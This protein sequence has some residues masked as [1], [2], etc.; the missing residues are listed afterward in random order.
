MS[1]TKKQNTELSFAIALTKLGDFYK[2][3]IY[4]KR[5]VQALE[6]DLKINK[7]INIEDN[8]CTSKDPKDIA[9][10]KLKMQSLCLAYHHLASIKKNKEDHSKAFEFF[11]L[12][13]SISKKYVKDKKL[14]KIINEDT[15]KSKP[16]ISLF[17]KKKFFG[18]NIRMS[19]VK[20]QMATEKDLLSEIFGK[21]EEKRKKYM[22]PNLS[23]SSLPM[24]FNESL[25]SISTNLHENSFKPLDKKI[26]NRAETVFIASNRGFP[27]SNTKAKVPSDIRNLRKIENKAALIIQKFFKKI[28]KKK[29]LVSIPF[30]EKL[31]K[32]KT[33]TYEDIVESSLLG[34]S[35]DFLKENSPRH[36]PNSSFLTIES[37]IPEKSNDSN[38]P[39]EKTEPEILL[40]SRPDQ[41]LS[42]TSSPSLFQ[43]LALSKVDLYISHSILNKLYT[44]KI[45]V[46]NF[47]VF[48][49]SIQY[50][51]IISGTYDK[52]T[53]TLYYSRIVTFDIIKNE[54]FFYPFGFQTVWPIIRSEIIPEQDLNLDYDDEG[55]IEYI[56]DL[57]HYIIN[58]SSIDYTMSGPRL[59]FRPKTPTPPE[60]LPEFE[61]NPHLYSKDGVLSSLLIFSKHEKPVLRNIQ[62]L[63]DKEELESIGRT[64]E[65]GI[66][67]ICDTYLMLR[68]QIISYDPVH[69]T[70]LNLILTS[71][72]SNWTETFVLSW[73]RVVELFRSTGFD[74]DIGDVFCTGRLP[75][76]ARDLFYSHFS[77][78]FSIEG[79]KI[80]IKK[81][82]VENAIDIDNIFMT[83]SSSIQECHAEWDQVLENSEYLNSVRDTDS[84]CLGVIPCVSLKGEKDLVHLK[85]TV[86]NKNVII[87]A[88]PR[89]SETMLSLVVTDFYT[90][91]RLQKIFEMREVV[92]TTVMNELCVKKKYCGKILSCDKYNLQT[93][94]AGIRRIG[95]LKYLVYLS[96]GSQIVISLYSLDNCR[97]IETVF[98]FEDLKE[99][100]VG[101]S[102]G[103]PT[104]IYHERYFFNPLIENFEVFRGIIGWFTGWKQRPEDENVSVEGH[105]ISSFS[106]SSLK[107]RKQQNLIISKP[108]FERKISEVLKEPKNYLMETVHQEETILQRTKLVC[109][110]YTLVTI[111][112][113]QLLEEWRLYL[114]I[115]Q[116]SRTFVCKLYDSDFFSLEENAFDKA[117]ENPSHIVTT[118]KS[119]VKLWEAMIFEGV[120][121]HHSSLDFVFK[122]DTIIAPMRELLY[123]YNVKYNTHYYYEVFIKSNVPFNVSFKAITSMKETEYVILTF[124]SYSL[125]KKIWVKSSL[126]LKEC[127]L[128]LLN[129]GIV[130]E[131]IL[132]STF[133]NYSQLKLYAGVL[134]RLVKMKNKENIVPV[135]LLPELEFS[136]PDEDDIF[137]EKDSEAHSISDI[138]YQDLL[139]YQYVY[140]LNPTIIAGSYFNQIADEFAI[141]IYNPQSGTLYRLPI[142]KKQIFRVIPFSKTLLKNK[143]NITL[144]T[145]I[146]QSLLQRVLYQVQALN[147]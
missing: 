68:L 63:R 119:N 33:R 26:T 124:R 18:G 53:D 66:V 60:A 14:L 91:Y 81:A 93:T 4:A 105:S 141:K 27:D 10:F 99:Y 71:L 54:T 7:T 78:Y 139:L 74:L 44:W 85:F 109:G 59:V 75:L 125:H 45:S 25:P 80:C 96:I 89:M 133:I 147:H 48:S 65:K 5:A 69:S 123:S 6:R 35:N 106:F 82:P 61:A 135:K 111:T 37:I 92:K 104:A 16:K 84:T 128:V 98:G 11:E 29:F 117:Y 121:Q 144:G 56:K 120:F 36:N 145:N 103:E 15:N 79:S 9:K 43:V 28:S 127:V 8:I 51:F 142:S 87:N 72:S 113:L 39:L 31:E 102:L 130:D 57:A 21:N 108:I 95:G 41:E 40:S 62:D 110:L 94:Y 114:H 47:K 107:F 58:K 140:S 38:R 97:I 115:F 49:Q 131:N 34:Y 122:F 13:K 126:K 90:A 132:L 134:C 73:D 112:K 23:Y 143:V 137:E 1:K 100:F 42:N 138:F 83:A 146:L 55:S 46:E 12:S 52:F 64:I 67:F 50:Q 70:A 19:T 88:K 32:K 24:F 86:F 2:A 17:N 129:K 22:T 3:E 30:A 118:S 136:E 20:S 116:N 101:L 77:D 76:K